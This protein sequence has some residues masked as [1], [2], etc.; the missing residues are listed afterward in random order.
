MPRANTLQPSF[1]AGELRPRMAARVDFSQYDNAAET[2][3]NLLPLPQG[4]AARRPGTR[5]VAD[6]ASHT[7]KPRLVPFVFSTI[8]AYVLEFG[9][10]ILRVFKDQG[11]VTASSTDAAITNGSFTKRLEGWSD[12]STGSARLTFSNTAADVLGTF[13]N[14]NTAYVSFGDA[15]ANKKLVGA[16]FA[17]GPITKFVT[18]IVVKSGATHNVSANVVAKIYT[19]SGGSPGTQLGGDSD[20]VLWN[21][22]ATEFTFVWSSDSP[23]VE[24]GFLW[25]VLESAAGLNT[26]I[27]TCDDQ[28]VPDSGFH[29]TVTSIADGSGSFPL[30]Q[31]LR[32]KVIV[33]E[34]E[35][36]GYFGAEVDGFELFGATS[37]FGKKGFGLQFTAINSGL[38]LDVSS[39]W[40]AA[41]ASGTVFAQ[42]YEDLAGAPDGASP[43]GGNSDSV[44]VSDGG[45]KT[46]GWSSYPPTL[47]AGSL[48]W[49]VIEESTTTG[50]FVLP[51]SVDAAGFK[52]GLGSVVEANFDPDGVSGSDVQIAVRLMD[53]SVDG[54]LSLHGTAGNIAHAE[55][56]ITGVLTAHNKNNVLA[57]EVAGIAGDTVKLRIGTSSGGT[58]IIDDQEFSVGFH[59]VTFVPGEETFYVG[60]LN[61]SAKAI[62]IG[63]VSFLDSTALSLQS[64]YAE[65]D[66]ATLKWAQTA[67]ILYP[68]AGGSSSVYRLERHADT[69]WSLEEVRFF[70]GPYLV[71][72]DTTTTLN[73]GASTGLGVSLEASQDLF[74][75]TDIGRLVR[76][77]NASAY[78]HAIIT[79]FSDPRHV[80][81]DVLEDFDGSSAKTTWNLGAWSA[82]TGYPTALSFF[83]QRSAW[84]GTEHQPQTFWLSQSADIENMRADDGSGTVE[85]DDAI[86]F[87]FAADQVN[88]I[89][90]ISPGAD[91]VV[92]TVGGEW[93][94]SSSA[95]VLTPTDIQVRRH[96]TMGGADTQPLRARARLLFV[97]RAKRKLLEFGFNFEVDGFEALDMTLLADHV[98]QSGIVEM[99]YQQEPDSTIWCLR[100]DGRL[101]SFAYQPDQKVIGWSRQIIGGSFGGGHA[102]VESL[103][104]IPGAARDEVWLTVKRTIG[105]ET[106]RF[107]EF[108]EASHESCDEQV[109]AFF[110]NSGLSLDQ[111]NTDVD[112]LLTLSAN[113]SWLAGASGTLTATR[114]RKSASFPAWT[115]SRARVCRSWPTAQCTA[116]KW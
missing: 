34:G 92:G 50:S 4:G 59:T 109:A 95:S 80:T 23:M 86:D 56:E 44:V 11:Q 17:S 16:R 58:D 83:E 77:K 73:P 54:R 33:S 74:A 25:V 65:G 70:D 110:V 71:E 116:P 27:E 64:P 51:V 32:V 39:I 84:A 104:V 88:A 47:S 43:V 18:T 5:Y 13:D 38:V 9:D 67:D 22:A 113:G 81:I 105:G 75:A 96:S 24:A 66:L 19:D 8:Q 52:S 3:E 102:I 20:A 72:N 112:R 90:W 97:Q 115:I 53:N 111:R 63:N 108:I 100:G 30:A 1:N 40:T 93:L 94:V 7:V 6:A 55:Q 89:R 79:A 60:F 78:G 107:V 76:F 29:D 82:T 62:Q 91:L 15:I 106:R 99:V 61:E 36:Q 46:F 85:D 49:V 87:T 98:T 31:D 21:Q 69:S 45:T 103:A 57:F 37:A 68:V 101:A 28:F 41:L 35:D 48:Y 114:R 10:H 14:P 42:I 12:L 2:M 26:T